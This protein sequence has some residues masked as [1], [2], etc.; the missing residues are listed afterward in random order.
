MIAPEHILNYF[1]IILRFANKNKVKSLFAKLGY[2]ID[3]PTPELC[4]QAYNEYGVTFTK[5][6]GKIAAQ[7]IDSPKYTAYMKAL[8]SGKPEY[9]AKI[10]KANGL[11]SEQSVELAGTILSS[12]T[13]WIE[14]GKDMADTIVNKDTNAMN[15]QANLLTAQAAANA[16]NTETQNK[17][18]IPV[19]ICIAVVIL[20]GIVA[21]AIVANK[22]K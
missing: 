18:L 21:A 7:A 2:D 6:F 10:T 13:S 14:S 20:G 15:A 17:W 16:K 11:S 12:I 4:V 5:P 9:D 3:E 1:T 8:A 22:H 19:I